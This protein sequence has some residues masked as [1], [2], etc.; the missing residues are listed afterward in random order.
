MEIAKYMSMYD[1]HDFYKAIKVDG[2]E[3][4]WC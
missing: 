3:K 1:A 4:H 2:I